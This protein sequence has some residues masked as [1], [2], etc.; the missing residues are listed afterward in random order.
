LRKRFQKNI[1]VFKT[2]SLALQLPLP[3]VLC[4]ELLLLVVVRILLSLALPGL[5]KLLV[6]CQAQAWWKS[7]LLLLDW[8]VSRPELSLLSLL[9]LLLLLSKSHC[10][11]LSKQLIL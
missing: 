7:S 4:V 3:T 9:L 10:L 2:E 8:L 5:G 1:S 11:L 6:L